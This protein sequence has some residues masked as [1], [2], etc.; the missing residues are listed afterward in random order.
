MAPKKYGL[1]AQ[2]LTKELRVTGGD[3]VSEQA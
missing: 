1:A 3:V 2:Q